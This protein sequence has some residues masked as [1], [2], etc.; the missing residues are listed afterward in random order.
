MPMNKAALAAAVGFLGGAILA[1][2][3]ATGMYATESRLLDEK[4]ALLVDEQVQLRA[5]EQ[6][7]ADREAQA[8]RSTVL[9]EPCGLTVANGLAS[10]QAGPALTA[11]G[12]PQCAAW[13]I[14]G[15][16]DVRR[17][18]AA[19]GGLVLHADERGRPMGPAKIAARMPGFEGAR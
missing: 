19:P 1:A 11:A 3:A 4:T 13:A 12:M 15:D 14:A 16:V 2:A 10:I 6:Q 17:W 7:A 5:L 9:Y 18:G 8:R